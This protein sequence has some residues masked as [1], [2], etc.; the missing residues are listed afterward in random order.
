MLELILARLQWAV[1]VGFGLHPRRLRQVK[2][3]LHLL[4]CEVLL[5]LQEA[6]DRLAAAT[7]LADYEVA[8]Q[9]VLGFEPFGFGFESRGAVEFVLQIVLDVSQ[10]LILF[11][12]QRNL[13]L[14][15][16]DFGV[17]AVTFHL[18]LA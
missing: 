10:A 16:P 18:Q 2:R 17:S 8:D 6:L 4:L 7:T 9:L 5:D 15:Q 1:P 13:V 12:D 14:E 11:V 3:G